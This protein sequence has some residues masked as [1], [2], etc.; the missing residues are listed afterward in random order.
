MIMKFPMPLLELIIVVGDDG[1]VDGVVCCI[2][3]RDSEYSFGSNRPHL[4]VFG[5]SLTSII[6]ITVGVILYEHLLGIIRSLT[7]TNNLIDL[8]DD[9]EWVLRN[10]SSLE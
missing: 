6:S 9:I 5:L 1:G 7:R 2:N 8:S 10:C 3:L 4:I